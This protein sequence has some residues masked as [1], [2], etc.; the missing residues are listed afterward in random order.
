MQIT[1]CVNNITIRINGETHILPQT[2]IYNKKVGYKFILK[3]NFIL[4]NN[5]SIVITPNRVNFL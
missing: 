2:F 4:G 1:E 3:L 5:D